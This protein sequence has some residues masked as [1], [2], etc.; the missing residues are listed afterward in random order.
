MMWKVSNNRQL[1]EILVKSDECA[2]LAIGYR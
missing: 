2:V 1:P